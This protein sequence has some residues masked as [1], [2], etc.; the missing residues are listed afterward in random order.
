MIWRLFKR[1]APRGL[2]VET[3]HRRINDASRQPGLYTGLGVPDTVEGRFECLCLH[4]ILVLRRLETLPEPAADV[5]Q[6]LVNAVFLQLDS[7]LRELGVGDFG[8]PKRMKKLGAAFYGRAETYGAALATKDLAT[9]DG[10]ALATALARNVIGTPEPG[11]G[12]G[13]A[14]Y[15]LAAAAALEG[16]DLDALL[17]SGPGFPSPDAFTDQTGAP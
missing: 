16:T 14:R 8:V 1:E 3:L 5:A 9:K 17:A 15:V 11:D 4:V 13:L 6:D 12:A 10:E 2:A 7:S